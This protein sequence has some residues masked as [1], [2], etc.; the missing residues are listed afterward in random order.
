LASDRLARTRLTRRSHVPRISAPSRFRSVNRPN[1]SEVQPQPRRSAPGV[2]A[3]PLRLAL[4]PLSN[5][6][7]AKNRPRATLI[8]SP[9]FM[10][11]LHS[12]RATRLTR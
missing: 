4:Q 10:R 8:F 5:K 6:R 2:K 7:H 12:S 3:Q 1:S 11:T 9:T